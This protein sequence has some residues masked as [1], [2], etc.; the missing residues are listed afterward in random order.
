MSEYYQLAF[1]DPNNNLTAVILPY[2]S[3]DKY[4]CYP[5]EIG[6]QLEMI[7]GR[8]VMERRGN[9]QMISYS[10]DC[11]EDARWRLVAAFLRSGK[12]FTVQYLPDDGD[13][14]RVGSFIRQSMTPPKFAFVKDGVAYWHDIDFTLREV[15]PHD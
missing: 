2:T 5:E 7:S 3:R 6:S 10:Y 8:I 15:S 12:A 4:Q 11:M 14:Y 9:V 1:S 13:D